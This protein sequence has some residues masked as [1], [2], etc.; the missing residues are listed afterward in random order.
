MLLFN[1]DTHAGGLVQMKQGVIRPT[2]GTSIAVWREDEVLVVK[3]GK[4]PRKGAWALP[5]GHV[6][7][8][9][10]VREAAMRELLEETG[11]TAEIGAVADYV[12]IIR[13]GDGGL[14]EVH[15]VLIV[16][17]GTWIS[18]EVRAGD[19]A[20]AAAWIKPD[21]VDALEGG[22]LDTA[23]KVIALTRV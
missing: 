13:H 21:E 12:D 9:E 1:V 23:R 15:Y 3:R 6:E 16:F 22:I 8:G 14:V 5:G 19:D 4:M 7:A 2:L 20:E 10:T 18:G 17:S 11:I